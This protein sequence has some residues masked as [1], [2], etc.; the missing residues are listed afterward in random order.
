MNETKPDQLV[1]AAADSLRT[2]THQTRTG[3]LP[4]GCMTAPDAYTILG[5]AAELAYSLPQAL[6]QVGEALRRSLTV[7]DIYDRDRQPADSI[8][9]ATRALSAAADAFTQAAQHLSDAQAAIAHQ[10]VN[11]ESTGNLRRR[12]TLRLAPE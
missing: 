12:P 3:Q 6:T 4:N 5:S 9:I 1:A 7:F 11:E 2:F 8:A 10:G